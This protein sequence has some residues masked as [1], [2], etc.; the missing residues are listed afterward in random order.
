M[1]GKIPQAFIDDLISRTDIV[2]LIDARVPLKKAGHEYKAC[3]PFHGEKTPSF[4]VSPTKQFYHCFGCGAHGTAIGFLMEYD[5][6]SFPEAVEE[7][8]ARAGVEVPHSDDS[9]PQ[10]DYRPLYEILEQ[11]TRWFEQQLRHHPQAQEAVGYLKQRGVSGEMAARFHLGFAPPGWDNLAQALGRDTR[12]RRL[13]VEAGLVAEDGNRVRDRFRHRIIFPITDQRGRVIAF[14]GR[15]LGSQG[16]KY[17]NSPETPLFQKGAELYGFAQAREATRELPQILVVEGYMDLIALAQHG[18]PNVVATLGTAT[19]AQHVARLYRATADL[20]FCFDGD[21]AGRAA[22]WKALQATLPFMEHGRKAAFLFL[23]E[24]EDPD[25]LVR[26]IGADAMRELLQTATPLSQFLLQH[27]SDGLD[28]ASVEGRAMLQERAA[29]LLQRIPGGIYRELLEAELNQLSRRT[30]PAPPQAKPRAAAAKPAAGPGTITPERR[31][32]TLLLHHPEL[33]SLADLPQG[34]R[35]LDSSGVRLLKAMLEL[36]QQ[37]PNLSSAALIEHWDNPAL[38]EYL[39][40]LLSTPL[41][42]RGDLEEQFRGAL[43]KVEQRAR[44]AALENILDKSS[45]SDYSDE[46]KQRL[47]DLLQRQGKPTEPPPTRK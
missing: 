27:C 28:L 17:L 7:L 32:L 25:T 16:P 1:T 23:P 24:G 9:T 11:A 21:R 13:L 8:A 6:L 38:R 14:G 43:V 26:R 35:S 12:T 5:R 30:V 34:W 19:T 47:R 45:F 22:A 3:C 40:D 10:T 4:T 36:L 33:A 44:H 31:A 18:L 29:P 37:H 20:V 46:E 41:E 42:I 2:E 15:D 39:S